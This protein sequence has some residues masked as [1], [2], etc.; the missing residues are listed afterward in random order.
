M[1]GDPES[2][3]TGTRGLLLIMADTSAMHE[4]GEN[5]VGEVFVCNLHKH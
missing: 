1:Y 4:G 5:V 3:E 2:T